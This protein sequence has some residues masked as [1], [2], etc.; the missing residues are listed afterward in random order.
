MQSKLRTDKH[1][2]TRDIQGR[3]ISPDDREYKFK[4]V[5]KTIHG[6]L[7]KVKVYE[8]RPFVEYSNNPV[9]CKNF[10]DMQKGNESG[11]IKHS[12]IAEGE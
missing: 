1:G 6:Q 4:I 3:V 8:S 9:F 11:G 10:I 2:I 7:V 12:I 5:E